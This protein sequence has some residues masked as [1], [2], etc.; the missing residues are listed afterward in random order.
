VDYLLREQFF[1]E[2]QDGVFGQVFVCQD[3]AH[4]LLEVDFTVC[5]VAQAN[6]ISNA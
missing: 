1:N 5:S 4:P 3:P 6:R 2:W